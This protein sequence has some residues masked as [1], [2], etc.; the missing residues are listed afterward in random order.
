MIVNEGG[1]KLPKLT[2]PG[3]SSDL[4]TGKELIDQYGRKVE[5]SMPINSNEV[6]TFGTTELEKSGR[7][8]AT[9]IYR[10]GFYNGGTSS[11]SYYLP[12]QAGTTITPGTETKT[13]VPSGKYTLGA[14]EV[15]GDSDLKAENIKKGVD[16]FGVSGNYTGDIKFSECTVQNDGTR[17]KINEPNFGSFEGCIFFI[18]WADLGVYGESNFSEAKDMILSI[19]GNGINSTGDELET[20][21][22]HIG[23]QWN[24]KAFSAVTARDP[25]Y[26]NT[27]WL[28]GG[29]DI[30]DYIPIYKSSVDGSGY[31][32]IDIDTSLEP[33]GI[34]ALG[35]RYF[36]IKIPN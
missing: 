30:E 13:A 5:G 2:T 10:K 33:D 14:V 18:F 31:T 29:V 36:I 21:I 26:L 16:I 9:A 15:A 22:Q 27:R 11:T 32:Y 4:L 20:N 19:F 34:F 25:Y 1:K 28:F 17:L 23:D 3:T 12:T 7:L 6:P 24:F 35:T 8:R